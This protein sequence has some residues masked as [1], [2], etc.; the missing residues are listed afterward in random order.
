MSGRDGTI[1]AR[2]AI[3]GKIRRQL[4]VTAEDPKRNA[5]VDARLTRA[6][7][8]V[9][10]AR[11][12][13]DAAGRIALFTEKMEK[14]S[15]SVAR[16]TNVEAIPTAV[17]EYLR[18]HN[19]PAAVRMGEDALLN[20]LPWQ[21][22]SIEVSHGASE[23]SDAV[24]LSH[25]VAAVAESG[26]LVLTSG[27][28]NPTT[29]NFLPATHIVAVEAAAIAGDFEAVWAQLRKRYGKGVLP[30]TVNMVS[31]PSRSAD[32]EQKLQLGAHGPKDLHVIIVG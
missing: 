31:G 2:A 25:A 1:G 6:P 20:A 23:G 16:V 30:R 22:T 5:A 15:A 26:T 24:G 29:L 12:Q 10:P 21:K 28:D 27:A 4:G 14:A 32:I 19:L 7:K 9:V 17:A 18:A 8:G 3:L 11:G 13:L